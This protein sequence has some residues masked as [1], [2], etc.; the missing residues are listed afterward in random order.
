MVLGRSLAALREAVVERH[1][2]PRIGAPPAPARQTFLPPR[3]RRLASLTGVGALLLLTVGLRLDGLP[4]S[5]PVAYDEGWAAT[6]GRFLVSLLTHPGVW[7]QL[8]HGNL[9]VSIFG[10]HWKLGHDLILGT[11]MAAGVSPENLTWFSGLAGVVMVMV[12][13]ALA[14]RRWGAPAAAVAGTFAGAVPLG[15]IYGHR[16]VAEA[17]GLAGVAIVLY[18]IDR[19]WDGRPSRGLVLLTLGVFLPTLSLSYR[20]VPVLLPLLAVLVWLGWWYLRHDVPPRAPTGRLA[21]LCVVVPLL[22]LAVIYGLA[23]AGRSL[24]WF[25]L[26]AELQN[27]VLRSDGTVALPFAFLDFYPR[28]FWEFSGPAIIVA[29]AVGMAAL[30]WNWKKLDPLA[31]IAAGSLMGSLL[32]YTAAHDKVPR[33]IVVCVVFGAL[34]VARAVTLLERPALRWTMALIVCGAFLVTGWTGSGPAREASGTG[35]AGRW[36]ASH[37]GPMVATRAPDLVIYTERHWNVNVGL[38]PAHRIITPGA[39]ATIGSLRLQG[40]RWV[41]V[42]GHALIN[43]KSSVFEQLIGCGRPVAVFDDPAGWSR[44]QFLEE[45]NG[46]DLDY[47]GMLALRD[48]TLRVSRGE[49]TIRIYDLEGPGTD[50]CG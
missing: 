39:D 42:D 47:G 27:H 18:L 17:A 14:W 48:Q 36:L 22:A 11:L 26:P 38:D 8:R 49:E 6:T 43:S 21:S 20:L 46:L 41:V 40:A 3:A 31:A 35:A 50:A 9:H 13:M 32:F 37:P 15:I 24:S 4:G 1:G 16:I 30:T 34:V 29:A 5:G 33:A 2:V 44:V 19:W 7:P 23:L 25:R 28:T 12:L 10:R 45:A